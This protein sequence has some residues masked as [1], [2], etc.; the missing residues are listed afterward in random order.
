[1][2]FAPKGA[3]HI[4]PGQARMRAALGFMQRSKC[5]ALKGRN[6]RTRRRVA[7]S[8]RGNTRG[9]FNPGRCPGL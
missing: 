2:P 7:L 9:I 8:G 1:M 4:S 3:A 5:S 6:M